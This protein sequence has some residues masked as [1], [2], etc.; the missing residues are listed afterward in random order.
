MSMEALNEDLLTAKAQL[1]RGS[2]AANAAHEIGEAMAHTA[3]QLEID[4]MRAG[5]YIPYSNPNS[6]I[7]D[8]QVSPSGIISTLRTAAE[9]FGNARSGLV[10][11]MGE[12]DNEHIQN[13]GLHLYQAADI[14]QQDGSGAI[15]A[16]ERVKANIDA[17][18]EK[19]MALHGLIVGVNFVATRLQGRL[20]TS[21][22][23]AKLSM[24]SITSFQR[25]AG[26]PE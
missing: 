25:Q 23:E 3:S 6:L 21:A 10:T 24:E 15:P 8:S 7:P 17:I 13:A 1:E 4:A 11:T 22:S 14:L 20:K 16:A 26:L 9:L 18:N 5:G 19:I 2:T 12:S